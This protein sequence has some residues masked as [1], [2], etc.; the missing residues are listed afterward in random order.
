MAE[1]P[2]FAEPILHVDMD[3]FFVEVE[4]LSDE[5]LRGVPVVVGGLGS[6]GVV[7]AASYEARR[8][9]VHSAMP[10]GVARRLCPHA[11]YLPPNQGRYREVS[12]QV[13][14][15]FRSFT[16]LV[17]G[18]SVD[19][20]F[21]EVSGLRLHYPGPSEVGEHIRATV[22]HQLGLPASVG[23]ATNKFLA[24]LASEEAKPDGL[25]RVAAGSELAFLQP[26]PVRRLWGVGEATFA[27]LD[28]L[29][30]ATIGDLASVPLDSLERRLGSSLGRHLH[31]LANGVDGRSVSPDGA[32]KSISVEQ[33]FGR[34][35]SD[36]DVIETELLRQC[37]RVASR[38]RRAGL[39]GRTVTLKVRFP[40]FTTVTRSQSLESAIDVSHDLFGVVRELMGRV[41]LDRPVRLL[42]VGVSSLEA[43]GAPLQLGLDRPAAWDDVS[44]AVDAIRTRYGDEAV[45]PARLVSPPDRE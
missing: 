13:F 43:A 21:L 32:A 2:P 25:L 27:T 8:Y 35:L 36:A 28:G 20:A 40:D 18:L 23:A 37:E 5:T 9:G 12:E 24:K 17:E 34:D 6:R 1:P 15:V 22:R 44:T 14:R 39:A 19:E 16:P 42:G 4:R 3:A 26:L 30:V 45:S 7:A 29:G 10:V 11:R 31:R 38:L 33:T 41:D